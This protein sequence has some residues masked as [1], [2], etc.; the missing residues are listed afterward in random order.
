MGLPTCV[1]SSVWWKMYIYVCW[2]RTSLSAKKAQKQRKIK[3]SH[4]KNSAKLRKL[5]RAVSRNA[6]S[7]TSGSCSNR[8]YVLKEHCNSG[9]PTLIMPHAQ[10]SG[11]AI[12]SL[13][14]LG[15]LYFCLF[16]YLLL[17]CMYAWAR[18]IISPMLTRLPNCDDFVA[19]RI[20]RNYSPLATQLALSPPLG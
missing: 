3:I 9:I 14:I 17:F 8:H 12:I 6:P 2:T 4:P 16:D 20:L 5:A 18:R 19:E 13:Y 1:R 15:S 11:W 10:S 7:S